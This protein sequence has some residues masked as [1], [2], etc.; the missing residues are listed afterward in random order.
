MRTVK[1]VQREQL[2]E[3]IEGDIISWEK[4]PEVINK[5]YPE[6]K[7]RTFARVDQRIRSEGHDYYKLSFVKRDDWQE[8]STETVQKQ[9]EKGSMEL[10]N[11]VELLAL[12]K[13]SYLTLASDNLDWRDIVADFD[14]LI[15]RISELENTT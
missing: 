6:R 12:I 10:H 1:I 11:K 3:P 13:D 8:F 14:E 2:V 15:G 9:L 7:D 5:A 4:Q